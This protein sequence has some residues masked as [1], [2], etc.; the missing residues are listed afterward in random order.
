[1][2]HVTEKVEREVELS[3]LLDEVARE[4][5]DLDW[6]LALLETDTAG[7]MAF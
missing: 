2:S 5:A 1:V 4:P 7:A 6:P 3:A